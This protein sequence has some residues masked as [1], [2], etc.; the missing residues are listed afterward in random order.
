MTGGPITAEKLI[1]AVG[2]LA[3]VCIMLGAIGAIIVNRM[4]GDDA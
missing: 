2:I 1:E 4:R 3:V